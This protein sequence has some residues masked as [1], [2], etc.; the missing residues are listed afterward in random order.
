MSNVNR[1]P[2]RFGV[3]RYIAAL[4]NAADAIAQIEKIGWMAYNG[5]PTTPQQH[6]EALGTYRKCIAQLA[7]IRRS[8]DEPPNVSVAYD[9]YDDETSETGYLRSFE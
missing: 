4:D 8:L 3:P 2:D 5:Q 7:E 9:E 6:R 1:A